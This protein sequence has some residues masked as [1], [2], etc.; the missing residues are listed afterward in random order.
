MAPQVAGYDAWASGRVTGAGLP[1]ALST[2]L[3]GSFGPLAP[4]QPVAIDRPDAQDGRPDPRR[5][6]YPVGWNMPV[7]PPGSEGLKLATFGQLRAIADT[8]SVAR[9]CIS[10]RKQE[11]VGLDW[12]LIPT[13]AAEKKLRGD[14][15]GR[16]EW[17]ERRAKVMRFFRK[18]DPNYFS[19][20][21]WFSAQ[22]ED[23]LAVDALSL[24]LHPPRV[25]GKGAMGSNLA[26]LELIDGTTVRPMID[27]RGAR[28][29]PPNPAYQQ[30]MYGVPR[31]D[32]MTVMSGEDIKDMGEAKY[33]EYSGDQLMYLPYEARDWTPYGFAP[34]EKALVPILS[35]MNRQNWQLQ[36]FSEGTIPGLFVT[37]G[38]ENATPTQIRELQDALNAMA[39]DPAWRHKIIVLQKGS[40]TSPQVPAELA[41]HFDEI[42]MTQV[43]MGFDVMPMELGISPRTS[44]SQSSGA[45][46]QM[47]KKSTSTHDRK[48]N[49]PLLKRFMEVFD[50]IVQVVLKQ[51]DMRFMFEGLEGAE[52]EE[53]QV[54][55]I[56]NK[57]SHGMMSVDEGRIELGEQPWGLPITSD[58]VWATATGLVPLG[59]MD[60]KTGQ[61]PPPPM[62]PGMA[63]PAPGGP[64]A[65]RP[66]GPAPKPQPAGGG[67]PAAPT[68]AHAGAKQT[69]QVMG[70]PT[71]QGATKSVDTFA[72]LR[73]LDLIRRRLNKGGTIAGWRH[74]HIPDQVFTDLADDITTMPLGEAINRARVTVKTVGHLQHR[75]AACAQIQAEL[76][77]TLHRLAAGIDDG[78]VSTVGFVDTATDAMR[79]A[80]RDALRV[81]AAHALGT[82]PTVKAAQGDAN[83]V[84]SFGGRFSLYAGQVVQAYEQGFGLATVGSAEDPDNIVVRWHAKPGACVLCA[85]RDGRAFTVG[86]LPGWPG[87][88]GFG[89]LSDTGEVVSRSDLCLCLGGPNCRCRLAYETITP[90]QA[91]P[92]DRP[93][94]IP[95]TPGGTSG[96]IPDLVP[97]GPTTPAM[98]ER[99]QDV[100]DVAWAL[101]QPDP[102]AAVGGVFDHIAA[103]SA[104]RQRPYL[105][106]L[107]KAVLS[108]AT[109][110]AEVAAI[111][112][113]VVAAAHQGQPP[114]QVDPAT[115]A[116]LQQAQGQPAVVVKAA[117]DL[118]DP[119]PV[120]AEH[121]KALMRANYPDKALGWMDNARWVGPVQ[122]PVD[123]VDM[124]DVDSWA[125]STDKARVKHFTR[126]IRGG[127]KL[128]PVV[129]VQEPGETRIKIIDG[130]HRTL[131]YRKAGQP[132]T[133]YIGFVDA[134]GGPWDQTHTYQVHHGPDPANKV[135][136]PDLVKVGP[137]GYIHGWI[138][139]GPGVVGERVHHP[140]LGAGTVSRAGAATVGVHFDS[141]AYHAF[142]HGHPGP[143]HGGTHFVS[144]TTP[145]RP[146]KTPPK[147]EAVKPAARPRKTAPAKAAPAAPAKP[148]VRRSVAKARSIRDINAAAAAE[149]KRITGRDIHFDMTGSRP[150]LAKEH[151]EGI[152]R[153]LEAHPEVRLERVGTARLPFGTYANAD[154]FGRY[155]DFSLVGQER[156]E[157][158]YRRVLAITE[159][160]GEFVA[161]TPMGV[162]LHEFGHIVAGRHNAA[163][164][165]SERWA[166]NYTRDVLGQRDVGQAVRAQISDYAGTSFNEMMAEAFAD[167]MVNGDAAKPMSRY[168]IE[169]L[170]AK[171]GAESAPLRS[172]DWLLREA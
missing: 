122:V 85:T 93:T 134:D 9:A 42:V 96:L 16:R 81:G 82:A 170:H 140:E 2:F 103:R 148:Q 41:G 166:G 61:V 59:G 28:P 104:E 15:A 3:D 157:D 141:G 63:P 88:G 116:A 123:R 87:D 22:L 108:K 163:H 5:W 68:P 146:T 94:T 62:P 142:D 33:R 10:L 75:A 74:E 162:A 35:G 38:D 138:K 168:L 118:G 84:D 23:V 58:P 98:V 31:V 55:I 45:A 136:A 48:A 46:N 150:G 135:W 111:V 71:T 26:A 12:D 159:R 120:E 99:H 76:V 86:G 155:I 128:H 151:V 13:K 143:G 165:P 43:C 152:L 95:T 114:A 67:A 139:V 56:V 110:A 129:A 131:A 133:A 119:N 106:G 25:S 169:R 113:I 172:G 72:A 105:M 92:A 34:V 124:D 30:Y 52:D 117:A 32:L 4:I 7:G 69:D 66:A 127:D 158:A 101:T 21:T 29:A 137:K 160:D 100:Q 90:G 83:W 80:Y 8:Y 78:T 37:T 156:G 70:R 89:K 60:P 17:D 65:P 47:A 145:K 164:G 53:T 121:V 109:T 97:P 149:A 161:G 77:G 51:D 20:G 54:N 11:L 167:V 14:K 6:Q 171:I 49:V 125:A 91:A 19:F 39:G 27:L 144:R 24:Y 107:L 153:G 102:T 115:A 44:S 73:E 50:F 112:A 64:T 40:T 18:P 130:H 147:V 126:A 1:R 154:P 36:Y 79:V 132:V 57:V